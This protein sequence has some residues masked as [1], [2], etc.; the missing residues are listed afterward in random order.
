MVLQG[1]EEATRSLLGDARLACGGLRV[2]A[3][4]RRLAVCV[5]QLAG[6]QPGRRVRVTGP[7]RKAAFDAEGQPTR[8]AEGFARSQ[9]VALDQLAVVLTDRGE[10]LA[11]EREEAGQPAREVVPE[12]LER[13]AAS[14]P[15][16]RQMRWG[17]G[18][19]RFVRPVRWVVALL[20]AEVLPVTVAGVRAGRVTYGHRFLSPHPIDLAHACEYVDRLEGAVVLP[21]VAGRRDRIRREVESAAAARGVRAVVDDG[22]LETVVHL[23]EYPMAIAGS[24]P[25]SY[26]GLPREVVE[27][28]I[29]RHQRCFTVEDSGGALAPG[30]VAVSNLP[31]CDPAE[32]RHGNERVIRAR[33]ADADFYFQD[34]LK[35]TPE[36]RLPLLGAM[37]FQERLGSQLE[38]TERLVALATYLSSRLLVQAPEPVV[39]AARLAKSDLASGMV[40]EFPEL[41]GIIGEEYALRAGEPRA[42]ARAI[43]EQY[44]PRSA[45][46][47]LPGSIEG[48][49]LAIADKVDT[50]VGCVGVG[51]TP[52]GSQDPYALRRQ[53]QGVIQIVLERQC[54][55]SLGALVDRAL[56]LLG[57][58]VT[59]PMAVTR[60]RVLGLFRVRLATTMTARGVRADVVDAVLAQGFDEPLR[61]IQRAEALTTLMGRPDWEP[62]AVAFKRAINILPARPIGPVDPS[63]FVDEAERRLHRET[64]ALR[65]R[66]VRALE[67]G[68]YATALT[69]LASLRSA[70]DQFFE[71][72]MV[73]DADPK[74]QEN[75]L[76]LLKAIADLVL[77]VADLRKIHAAK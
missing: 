9:G 44:L 6:Q 10:Y 11:V 76:G 56:E 34:D 70:V 21:E 14:F 62:L 2:Y 42:V 17:E 71:A 28:S 51:L 47:E 63:R 55:L 22:T 24:F 57:P 66:V 52:T 59:E 69:E 65:P 61:A 77:P 37:V 23:V 25:E 36:D 7:P 5:G 3:T 75:R 54:A 50:V 39:R 29:R 35:H 41:Q 26:L 15:F 18:D 74:I 68:D 32:I 53:S 12:L 40:R 38:K 30:F 48:A 45:D 67:R 49:I 4:P 13:L 73:M 46:D 72:V 31:G 27:T 43:R 8:A 33:L 58:K 16:A 19:F 20:D 60:E 64:S 1:L